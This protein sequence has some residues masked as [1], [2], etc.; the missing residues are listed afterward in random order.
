MEFFAILLMMISLA[1]FSFRDYRYSIGLYAL[2][3]VVLVSLFF[4]FMGN[5]CDYYKGYFSACCFILYSW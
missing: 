2:N 1:V 5:N 3:T 4:I